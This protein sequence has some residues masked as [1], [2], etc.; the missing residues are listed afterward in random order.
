MQMENYYTAINNYFDKIYVLT[1]PRL[2]QR[3][4][5]IARQL[6]GLNYELFFGVDKEYTSLQGLEAQ[7][8]YNN[9]RY[10]QFYKRPPHMSL[11]MLC[12]SLGHVQMYQSIIANNYQRTLILEDDVFPL[13]DNLALFPAIISELPADWQVFYLG[14]EKN[15]KLGWWQQL[16]RLVYMTWPHHTKLHLT[17]SQYAHYYPRTLSTHIARAGFHDCTHAYAVTREG[18]QQLLQLQTPV[19]FNADNLLSYGISRQM[20]KAYIAR[21]KLFNQ[22]TAFTDQMTSLTEN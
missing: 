14:Y 18:A 2:Q 22:L 4:A 12:C 6:K 5:L 11:G 20:I 3:A 9:D 17:S 13:K 1:L 15:E 16:K 7:G 21:P 19:A 8:I 10:K